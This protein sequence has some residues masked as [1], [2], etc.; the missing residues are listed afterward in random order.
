[1]A[2]PAAN[3]LR[4][5]LARTPQQDQQLDEFHRRQREQ[6]QAE[7]AAR[8]Q[9]S[10]EARSANN[11]SS[12]LNSAHGSAFCGPNHALQALRR[13]R[14]AIQEDKEVRRLRSAPSQAQPVAPV[15]PAVAPVPADAACT[16]QIRLPAGRSIRVVVPGA[17]PLQRVRDEVQAAEHIAAPWCLV[18]AQPHRVWLS[19]VASIRVQGVQEFSDAAS[20]AQSVANL[21][22]APRAALIVH[23]TVQPTAGPPAAPDVVE[24]QPPVLQYSDDFDAEVEDA[25]PELDDDDEAA[26]GLGPALPPMPRRAR[27]GEAFGGPGVSVR[28]ATCALNTRRTPAC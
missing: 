3:P 5:R 25:E 14:Q 7:A 24:H 18:Q 27:I 26:P 13:A 16:L 23:C 6:A 20:L 22:L 2:D 12:P 17:A 28:C 10:D 8:Q 19:D 9:L 1:M 15:A 11:N 4:S 21:G